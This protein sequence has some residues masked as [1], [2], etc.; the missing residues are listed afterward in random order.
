[1]LGLRLGLGLG[2]VLFSAL[3][4]P[5]WTRSPMFDRLQRRSNSHLLFTQQFKI[6]NAVCT[7]QLR[8]YNSL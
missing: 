1:M 6:Q 2:L 8:P 5:A 4:G 7:M 3:L